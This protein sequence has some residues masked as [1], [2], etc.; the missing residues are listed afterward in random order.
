MPIEVGIWKL[1]DTIQ[2][3]QFISMLSEKRIEDI[4]ADEKVKDNLP[5]FSNPWICYSQMDA[6]RSRPGT[7]SLEHEQTGMLNTRL[8]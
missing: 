2:R 4:I 7:P 6:P 5:R 1:G 3:V 8:R